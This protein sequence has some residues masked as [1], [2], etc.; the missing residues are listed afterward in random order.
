MSKPAWLLW[1]VPGGLPLHLYLRSLLEQYAAQTGGAETSPQQKAAPLEG[2]A[3]RFPETPARSAE[4]MGRDA[5]CR[6]GASQH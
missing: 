2:W 6:K 1:P 4:A 5:I 3:E